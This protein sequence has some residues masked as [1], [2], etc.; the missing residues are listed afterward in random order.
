MLNIFMNHI[1]LGCAYLALARKHAP[2]EATGLSFSTCTRRKFMGDDNINVVSPKV[3]GWYTFRNVQAQ[4]QAFKIAYTPASK[5]EPVY[6]LKS[7]FSLNFLKI[8][9]T[10]RDELALPGVTYFPN[11]S[12]A[13][14][15]SCLKW[16]SRNDV[17][18]LDLCV[19]NCNGALRRTFGNGCREYNTLRDDLTRYFADA[20]HDIHL[21]SYDACRVQ[22]C[23]DPLVTAP[24]AS[25]PDWFSLSQQSVLAQAGFVQPQSGFKSGALGVTFD[26]A[27]PLL[28]SDGG[29]GIS[30]RPAMDEMKEAQIDFTSLVTRP[31]FIQTIEW[32][33]T[34]PAGEVLAAIPVPWGLIGSDL[35]S[36]PWKSFVYWHGTSVVELQMQ[37]QMF[38]AGMLQV[39]FVP[40]LLPSEAREIVNVNPVSR[41]V[42]PHVFLTAGQTE[43]VSFKIPFVSQKNRL[44]YS[45]GPTNENTLGTLLVTVFNEMRVSSATSA[46]GRVASLAIAG[47]FE[48]SSF[49]VLNPTPSQVVPIDYLDYIEPQ[50]GSMVSEDVKVDLE[51]PISTTMAGPPET[52]GPTVRARYSSVSELLKRTSPFGLVRPGPSGNFEFP[53][54]IAFT[55]GAQFSTLFTSYSCGNL[56]WWSK[57]FRFYKGG[58]RYKIVTQADCDVQYFPNGSNNSVVRFF[59]S[60]N[61][62][63]VTAMKPQV[64]TVQ[65]VHYADIQAPFYS[66]YKQL[67]IPLNRAEAY[68]VTENA[69]RICFNSET[70]QAVR[71]FAAADD[72]MRFS[73]LF[74]VPRLT[75]RSDIPPEESLALPPEGKVESQG[76]AYSSFSNVSKVLKRSID[77]AGEGIKLGGEITELFDYPNVGV[78]PPKYVRQGLPD[79]A[80]IENINSAQVLD[81]YPNKVI[82]Y[83]ADYAGTPVDEMSLMV[84]RS[85][86][87]YLGV[88]NWT[89]GQPTGEILYR[90]PLSPCPGALTTPVGSSYNPTLL[91]Y[92][93]LPFRYWKGSLELTVQIV[94]S[95]IA[96]GRLVVVSHYGTAAPDPGLPTAM[97]QYADV[98]DLAAGNATYKINFPWRAPSDTLLVPGAASIPTPLNTMGSFTLR[99]YTPL[100]TMDST[101]DAVEVNLYLNAGPD[102]SCDFLGGEADLFSVS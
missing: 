95:K 14:V 66:L 41:C 50:S 7:L 79:F 27:A 61:G 6:D 15:V 40:G 4:L 24:Y 42:C 70:N 11:T 78:N 83:E 55:Q 25:N 44:E 56:F 74:R 67:R 93:V 38:Q 60:Q 90:A 51:V 28:P 71:L 88:V 29:R 30:S 19:D 99:V 72:N 16:V 21:L 46:E 91:E 52:G 9:T 96:T 80:N 87:S 47:R 68:M 75:P 22:W 54:A 82:E 10:V 31:Q 57:L 13:E 69:G 43:N 45:L 23:A 94:A 101:A 100:R 18:A 97:S 1:F 39:Y 2:M 102:F 98:I 35:A 85:K 62:A 63:T 76:G 49:Q 65:N 12:R 5:E 20:G 37:S 89:V 26:D 53:C 36:Y 73:F 8:T 59:E 86:P 84:L 32:N 48:D 17:P 3:A 58:F 92:T 34:Q 33:D 81:A 64:S 77:Y